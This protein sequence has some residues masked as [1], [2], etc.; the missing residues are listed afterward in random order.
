[1]INPHDQETIDV[2]ERAQRHISGACKCPER[3]SD[4]PS[5]PECIHALELACGS[6][7][8][9][10]LE[11]LG[12]ARHEVWLTAM[13]HAARKRIEDL[14]A[15]VR[16]LMDRADSQSDLIGGLLE[17]VDALEAVGGPKP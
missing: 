2:Y 8:D 1:M 12:R 10:I 16:E 14:E 15:R 7:Q 3:L 4:G 6:A 9:E 5:S 13:A 11:A 17:R